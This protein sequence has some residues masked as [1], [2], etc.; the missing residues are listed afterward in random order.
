M[1][2]NVIS[3]GSKGNAVVIDGYILIDA[4]VS[5]KALS[6]VVGELKIVLLT[7]IHSD[8]F[9]SSTIK[10]LAF[11]KPL[12][13]FVCGEW[14]V[15][16]LLKLGVS[17]KQI[18]I[19]KEGMLY[20]YGFKELKISPVRLYHD[21]PNFGYRVFTGGKKVF[22]ATD[23]STLDGINAKGYD[24]YLVEANYEDKEIEERIAEKIEKGEYAYEIGAMNRH[25]SKKQ[26]DNF[27]YANASNKSEYIYLHCHEGLNF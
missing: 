2:Y 26:A 13:R 17:A 5:Y 19:V 9:R 11:T 6:E 10:K 8:H 23:T 27:I 16:P 14:L 4:G 24:L 25:L 3:T 15:E 18:D 21:V 7:H 22:Y 12:L 20:K 1:I